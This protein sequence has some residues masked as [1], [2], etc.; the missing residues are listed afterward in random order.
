MKI[1]LARD[2]PENED[3]YRGRLFL[4]YD[5]PELIFIWADKEEGTDSY[6]GFGHARMISEVPR[7][8]YPELKEGE[9]VTL[10]NRTI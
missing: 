4:F 6:Y 2:Y 8:M 3:S 10:E 7:Y 5:T 1:Y 9:C